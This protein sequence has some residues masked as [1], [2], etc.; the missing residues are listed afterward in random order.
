MNRVSVFLFILSAFSG[1]T[2]MARTQEH[3][4]EQER[5]SGYKD[6]VVESQIYDR[7]RLRSY[8]AFLESVEKDIFEKNKALRDFKKMKKLEKQESDA[9]EDYQAFLDS[10]KKEDKEYEIAKKEYQK[11]KKIG[12]AIEA[13]RDFTEAEELGIF[14]ERPRYDYKKRALY[15]AKPT[16]KTA[17]K[18]SNSGGSSGSGSG[19]YTPP[20]FAADSGYIPP[21][22]PPP[23]DMPNDTFYDEIPPPPPPPMPGADFGDGGMGDGYI[24]P[25]PPPPPMFDGEF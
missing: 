23:P 5:L 19:N 22:P 11:N 21:P 16:Y 14:V 13:K 7:E 8:R 1:A 2:L 15:G 25:P 9:V 24:P 10:K 18:S 3:Q 6:H 20:D 17:A 12:Q 4:L